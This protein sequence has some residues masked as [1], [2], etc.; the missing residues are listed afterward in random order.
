MSFLSLRFVEAMGA[1]SQ[2]ARGQCDILQAMC[3]KMDEL[4]TQLS[5]YFVFDKQKYTLEEYMGDVKQFKDQFKVR[6]R[7]TGCDFF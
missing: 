3:K 1:F 7:R 4:Y 2:E 6:L 5:E